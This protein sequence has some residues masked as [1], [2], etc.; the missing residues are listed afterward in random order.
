MSWLQAASR[1]QLQTESCII[2]V[3]AAPELL[4]VGARAGMQGASPPDRIRGAALWGLTRVAMQECEDL[5]IRWIDLAD[6]APCEAS[7]ATLA[8]EL[9]E[10]DDEDEVLL[11]AEGRY[12][13]RLSSEIEPPSAAPAPGVPLVPARLDFSTPGSFRHLEWRPLPTAD[14]EAGSDLA[15]DEVEIDVRAAGLN[16]RDV[17][18]AMGLLPE[19]AIE[20]G[21]CGPALGMEVAGV[22]RR[23]GA[24]AGVLPGDEVIAVAPAALAQR[25]R[26][27]AF[28]V[29]RKPESWSFAAAATVPTAFFTVYYALTELARLQPG[30]RLLIHGA[31]GG[32][33]IA[34]IQVARHLGAEVF[35]TAGTADK[36]ELVRLLG[37]DRVF[38][39]R[40]LRFADEVLQA[41]AGA[42]VDVVLNSLAGEAMRRN[43]R[44]LRPFGRMVE[45]GKRDFYENT[46]LALR[47]FRNNIAYFAFDADQLM[48]R[49]PEAARRVFAELMA[50]FAAGNLHPLP[51]RTFCASNIEAAFRQMQA[52][53]HIGKIVITFA[54]DFGCVGP[55]PAAPAPALRPDAAYLVTGGLCGF[56]LRTAQWLASRGARHLVLMSRTGNPTPEAQTALADLSRAGVS[57]ECLACDVTDRGAVQAALSRIRATRPLRGIVHAAAVIE[58]ALL[59]D[60]THGQL[61]RVL[62][63]KI[64]GALNLHEATC[65]CELDFFIVYSSATTLF[66]NPGQ[67]A[68]VAANMALEAFAAERRA[69]GLPATCVGWG[70][71][72][73]AGY[74]A[75]HE[76]VRDA[77]VGRI[78]GKPLQADEALSALDAVL[79]ADASHVGYL[80]LDWS[81]LGRFLPRARA[82]KFSELARLASRSPDAESA[83]D[84]RRWLK[85]LPDGELLPGLTDLLRRQIAHI[86]RIPPERIEPGASLSELGMDSLMAV[87]L[88]ASIEDRLGV[89]LSALSLGDA[90]TIE[91]IAA[92]LA[93][94]LRPD[95]EEAC[96]APVDTLADQVRTL[97]AQHATEVSDAQAAQ[98]STDLGR[99]TPGAPLTMGAAP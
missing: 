90:P 75:R 36:R 42:G 53:R 92:R 66:G 17:M 49:R 88:A 81:V 45:L 79:A 6:P 5:P 14:A 20:D 62:A 58:D 61:H 50:L 27:R 93:Q 78:G 94:Q 83:P 73:D 1:H 18:Y 34:A 59:R 15:A 89:R 87:E 43:I 76:R 67:G 32:V 31:A 44:L 72:A 13:L 70:P 29:A 7:A 51:Y 63:P 96:A 98:F 84:L 33:G 8:R 39:S 65:G 97:A 91:R 69:L 12:A 48:A 19:E 74:L 55:R 71:I 2:A 41:T 35:A 10:P 30:E 11:T 25:V 68:Y 95:R 38:D 47:P 52:S 57:V 60:L 21:F 64:A 24:D 4:P 56:G 54:D 82:P 26:T 46:R 77:L 80:E 22:V 28:G 3:Q 40:S 9:L 37:A 99:D 86:L 23:A 85:E 16:F